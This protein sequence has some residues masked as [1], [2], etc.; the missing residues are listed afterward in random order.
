MKLTKE[1]IVA[2]IDKH[3]NTEDGRYLWIESAAAAIVAALDEPETCAH[4]KGSGIEFISAGHGNVNEEPCSY[5]Q[6]RED[7]RTDL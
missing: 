1:Q 7:G 3:V 4:C 5:C 6:E 2:L